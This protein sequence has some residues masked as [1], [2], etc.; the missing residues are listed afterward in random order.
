MHGSE[1][2]ALDITGELSLG[3]TLDVVPIDLGVGVFQPQLGNVFEI[4]SA[5]AGIIGSFTSE[6]L[7]DLGPLL[8]MR[9][10]QQP[11]ELFLTVVP[12]LTGDYNANG[13]VDAADYVVWRNTLNQVGVGLA[14]D[15]NGN[16]T[17]DSGDLAVW[18]LH[19]GQTA[20]P[21][22]LAAVPHSQSEL[23]SG[24][25]RAGHACTADV[26]GGWLESPARPDRMEGLGPGHKARI[27]PGCRKQ[28]HGA[29][30]VGEIR[31]AGEIPSR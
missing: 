16:Y 30:A 25:S 15:G 23:G 10:V 31:I 17:I 28:N 13:I 26:C 27:G 20:A 1:Y 24:H 19:F 29:L 18:R 22:V 6:Q 3:G 21:G 8:D 12:G 5:T 7:P 2:D 11:N 9:V 14:A 4:A